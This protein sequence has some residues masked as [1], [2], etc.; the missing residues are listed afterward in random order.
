M[1]A[2]E[3]GRIRENIDYDKWEWGNED[4]NQFLRLP[5]SQTTSLLDLWGRKT[6]TVRPHFLFS[7]RTGLKSRGSREK[8]ENT[9]SLPPS[10]SM[11]SFLT[12][13]TIVTAGRPLT[14]G[15]GGKRETEAKGEVRAC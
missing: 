6:A 13:T 5:F 3:K 7:H 12:F 1:C 15:E 11:S 2:P 8:V 10:F 9:T 14:D 4:P